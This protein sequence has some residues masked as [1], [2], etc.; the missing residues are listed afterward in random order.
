MVMDD[1]CDDKFLETSRGKL[2]AKVASIFGRIGKILKSALDE[3]FL[4]T[5]PVYS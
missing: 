3:K 5:S 2:H 4:L 1:G